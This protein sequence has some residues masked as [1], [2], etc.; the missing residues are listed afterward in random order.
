MP[1]YCENCGS[2]LNENQ[3]FCLKCGKQVNEEKK[4]VSSDFDMTIFI[5]LLIVF[6]P[7]AIIYYIIKNK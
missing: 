4:S 1:K 6:W 3:D 2:E 5:I 7:G